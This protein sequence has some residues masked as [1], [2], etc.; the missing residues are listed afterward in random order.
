MNELTLR[1]STQTMSTLEIAEL[2]GKQHGHVKRDV[3]SVLK[4]A[5]IGAS[6]FGYTY[7]DTQNKEQSGID[8]LKFE[9]REKYGNNKEVA[10]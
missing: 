9:Q 4:Q 3:E 10:Q 8:V 5:G 1:A 2:T 7:K 6:K